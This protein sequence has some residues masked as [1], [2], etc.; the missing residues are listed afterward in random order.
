MKR[1]KVNGKPALGAEGHHE[2]L[3]DKA[4]EDSIS[5]NKGQ[6]VSRTRML[7]NLK[8]ALFFCRVQGR[9]ARGEQ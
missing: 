4:N 6:E 7:E 9:M 8:L 2:I 1:A 5:D 3:F